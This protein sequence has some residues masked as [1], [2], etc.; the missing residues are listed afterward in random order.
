MTTTST[1]PAAPVRPGLDHE[2]AM[3]L[4]ADEYERLVAVLEKLT[5]EQWAA[6]TDCPGWDVRAMAGHL[7]GM[8]QMAASVAETARQQLAAKKRAKRS[9]GLVLDA[10]TALQVE[11]N[12][13]LSTSDLLAAMRA[14]APRAAAARRRIPA[15]VRARTMP[16]P[17]LVGGQWEK[18]SAG[19]LLD[20]VLTRDPFLHRVDIARATGVSVPATAAHEGVIVDDVVREWAERHGAP[21]HLELSGPAGGT[22]SR[23]AGERIERDAFEFCRALSGR[24]PATGLLATQVPF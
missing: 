4:A 2:T 7:L 10:L 5:P 8:M 11:Q 17:Q 19:F 9:G 3:R 24:A 15:L 21:Y 16:E 13:P 14:T 12:A 23:G 22:W 1:S 18:W 20:V 6:P